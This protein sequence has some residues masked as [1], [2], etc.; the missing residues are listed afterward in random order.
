MLTSVFSKKLFL[1][2]IAVLLV[3]TAFAGVALVEA[4]A[5]SEPLPTS[6]ARLSVTGCDTE[7]WIPGAVSDSPNVRTLR[8]HCRILVGT[9]NSWAFHTDATNVSSHSILQNSGDRIAWG[10]GRFD[11]WQGITVD[12]FEDG[13]QYISELKLPGTDT[14][15][16]GGSIP[17]TLCQLS[18]VQQL[19]LSSNRF[20][21][22]IPSCLANNMNF[23]FF[24]LG[25]NELSGGIPAGFGRLPRLAVFE[26]YQNNLEG[27]LPGGF[28]S[29]IYLDVSDNSL[30]G[31]LPDSIGRNT[32][33]SATE[34]GTDPNE[35]DNAVS[36][37]TVFKLNSND[38]SGEIPSSYSRFTRI[39]I[40]DIANNNLTGDIDYSWLNSISFVNQRGH[41]PTLN[42][43]NN[44]LCFAQNSLITHRSLV[45]PDAANIFSGFA[46][47]QSKQPR[48][49]YGI[50]RLA[51]QLCEGGI[52]SP[53]G[54]LPPPGGINTEGERGEGGFRF[55][56]DVLPPVTNISKTL[57]EDRN[58][59]ML[60]WDAP[61]NPQTNQ[62]YT[63]VN[64]HIF[65]RASQDASL[66]NGQLIVPNSNRENA[67]VLEGQQG[68]TRST[69][70]RTFQVSLN[71]LTEGNAMP[72]SIDQY[73]VTITPYRIF[74]EPA[75]RGP[76]QPSPTPTTLP[77]LTSTTQ[78]NPAVAQPV[79]T[80]GTSM[81]ANYIFG[82]PSK[83]IVEGWRAYNVIA[84]GTSAQ[85]MA[86][87]LGVDRNDSIY[88]WDAA[89]QRWSEHP[90]LRDSGTLDQGTSVMFNK[91]VFGPDNL[92]FAG[93]SRADENMV[94]TLHQGWNI[95]APA[96]EE[97]AQEDFDDSGTVLFST[98]LV[99]CDNLAGILAIVT[100]DLVL[101]DFKIAL[102]CHP[103]LPIPAGYTALDALD[104]NDTMYVFFQSQLA[105][106]ITW[107]TRTNR[108]G[109]A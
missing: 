80:I 85:R 107:D 22:S 4:S 82:E 28:P 16:L 83:G 98:S 40:F 45:E 24:S 29:L 64:Y 23:T 60:S 87:N 69:P 27:S 67:P 39:N 55:S 92:R 93:L 81:F 30:S 94:L 48:Y 65:I 47:T 33:T 21:G 106:P 3:G 101:Q 20:S 74:R 71:D 61:L 11:A 34:P 9:Y 7:A 58:S 103:N 84:N 49:M 18:N 15:R 52:Q 66:N 8:Q 35:A 109:P 99:D 13:R 17:V 68:Y 76:M 12:T 63:G 73:V 70:F 53:S 95:L 1:S 38:F 90:A 6:P 104:E 59:M 62:G 14:G 56:P 10:T 105:V 36:N 75:L 37:L 19:D 32:N 89:V 96:V 51:G 43:E 5:Q 26:V 88:S 46:K 54:M 31:T 42:L 108:Y 100:Y 57:S 86:S 91:G 78:P 41:Q 25:D 44:R 79:P 50:F 102:P 72:L 2:F 97:L 77:S